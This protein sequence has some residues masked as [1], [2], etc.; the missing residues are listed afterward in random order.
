MNGPDR[1]PL[2]V[3]RPCPRCD[4]VSDDPQHNQEHWCPWCALYHTDDYEPY[5]WTELDR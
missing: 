1:R 2:H 5:W 3:V 4:R